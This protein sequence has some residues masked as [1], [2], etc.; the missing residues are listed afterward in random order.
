MRRSANEKVNLTVQIE[1]LELLVAER[2]QLLGRHAR[3]FAHDIR[4]RLTSP[5]SLLVAAGIG[6][7]AGKVSN[8]LQPARS[9]R[10]GTA[11]ASA[12]VAWRDLLLNLAINAFHVAIP[13]LFAYWHSRGAAAAPPPRSAPIYGRQPGS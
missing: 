12:N 11:E 4:R 3:I 1:Q 7:L 5:T 6:F 10:R 8:R 2:Q 13:R 9:P